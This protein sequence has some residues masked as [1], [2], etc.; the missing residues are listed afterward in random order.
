MYSQQNHN[1][2]IKIKLNLKKRTESRGKFRVSS[3]PL[4]SPPSFPLPSPFPS[5]LPP[6]FFPSPPLL[7]PPPP[8][9]YSKMLDSLPQ[10]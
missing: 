8:S 5:S 6:S 9:S 1:M 4:P 2:I 3:P 7:L 10:E